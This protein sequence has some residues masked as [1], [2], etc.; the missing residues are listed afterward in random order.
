MARRAARVARLAAALTEQCAPDP[1]SSREA[2]P[3]VISASCG[4]FVPPGVAS[5]W[6]TLPRR[7]GTGYARRRWLRR[8]LAS[9]RRTPRPGSRPSEPSSQ[10]CSVAPVAARTHSR[11][12]R[13]VRPSPSTI[14]NARA[15][16]R[17]RTLATPNSEGPPVRPIA[18]AD[19]GRA[20]ASPRPGNPARSRASFTGHAAPLVR[21]VPG[22]RGQRALRLGTRRLSRWFAAN[23]AGHCREHPPRRLDRRCAPKPTTR[24]KGDVRPVDRSSF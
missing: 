12:R 2:L 5:R 4:V 7:I 6:E 14:G 21:Q 20:S 9:M 18:L 19:R 8:D 13:R 16:G 23:E 1:E 3:K 11:R 17:L 10:S 15:G 22:S 24:F